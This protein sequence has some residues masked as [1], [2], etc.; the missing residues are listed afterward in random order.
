MK[1]DPLT[2]GLIIFA[3]VILSVYYYRQFLKWR[4]QQK[5]ITWP[6]KI[7]NCPDYW[8]EKADGQCENVLNL[9]TGSCGGG[10]GALKSF[11]FTTGPFKGETGDIQK[12][13]W[14]KKCD[15]SWEG[16]DDLCA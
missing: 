8:N 9:P 5:D 4:A 3:G 15:T 7:E 12:C 2:I 14:S 11:S 10:S 16:I 1:T 13:N 6:V